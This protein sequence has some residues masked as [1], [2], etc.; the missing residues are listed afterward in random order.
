MFWTDITG[1]ELIATCYPWFLGTYDAYPEPIMRADAVR[2][3]ILHRYGGVYADLDYECLRP[4]YAILEGRQ[5]VMGLE[6][7]E[8]AETAEARASGSSGPVSNALMASIPGHAFWE[9]VFR[10][11]M[12][13]RNGR[14][15]LDVTGSVLLTRAW[16]SYPD[17]AFISV[18][19]APLLNPITKNEARCGFWLDPAFRERAGAHAWAVH[20]W[21][22]SWVRQ[23][24]RFPP[25]EKCPVHLLRN[26]RIVMRGA[27]RSDVLGNVSDM[28]SGPLISC[29]MVTRDRARL[30]AASIRSFCGQTYRDRE[31]VVLDE[32]GDNALGRHVAA[33][34]DPAIRYVRLEPQGLT[35]G[36]LRNL[37]VQESRG[38]F[39]ARWDEG[40][41]SHLRRLEL[42]MAAIRS[43]ETAASFLLRKLIWWPDEGRIAIA[44]SRVW[45]STMLCRK[46]GCGKD[47]LCRNGGLPPYPARRSGEGTPV[48]A[49]LMREKRIALVDAPQLYIHVRPG[50]NTFGEDRIDRQWA[51]A[52]ARFEGPDCE[53]VL[54]ELAE[55]CSFGDYTAERGRGGTAPKLKN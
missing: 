11:L 1:R 53:D 50:A 33:L 19:D 16:E 43:L 29:V 2:Y 45:E 32:S 44:R 48:V 24:A 54:Q 55:S 22:G 5:L 17:R 31:L 37:A 4:F 9:H 25:L 21:A 20:H 51:L 26:R 36:E 38:K 7:S 15:P 40:D 49:R 46:E 18:L 14:R 52:D 41:I 35:L 10:K 23:S 30:A 8:H 28:V 13:D 39:V 6:P 47:A 27:L 12:N 3:F 42:Q 34:A